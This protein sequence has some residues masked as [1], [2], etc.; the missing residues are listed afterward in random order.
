MER[1]IIE[2]ENLLPPE[3]IEPFSHWLF[4]WYGPELSVSGFAEGIVFLSTMAG[5]FTVELNSGRTKKVSELKMAAHVTPWTSFYTQDHARRDM[6]H[7]HP[8]A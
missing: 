5:F 8:S 7:I 4:G 2:L 3:A 6:G 1:R